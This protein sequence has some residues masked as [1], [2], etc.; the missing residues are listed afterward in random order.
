MRTS[1]Y[2]YY[3]HTY[4][5]YTYYGYPYTSYGRLLTR[6]SGVRSSK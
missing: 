4:Q 3:G 6:L 2:T 5:G 1:G